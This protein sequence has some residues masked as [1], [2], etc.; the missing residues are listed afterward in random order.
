[1]NLVD[2]SG[3]LEYFA[4]GKNAKFFAP[5]LENSSEL[6][7]SVI[8]LYEVYKKVLLEKDDESAIQAIALMQQS[9]VVE[10]TSSISILAA[11][12]SVKLKIPM[13]DSIIYATAKTY[14]AIVWTQDSDFENLEGVKYFKNTSKR[15]NS[16]GC[17]KV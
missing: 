6:I 11:R 3:W 7:V 8:N 10:I 5:T 9:K 13:A 2:S 17:P 16:F 1:M 14:N 4:D 12:L 15:A